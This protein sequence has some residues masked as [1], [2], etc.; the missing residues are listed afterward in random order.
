ML[1]PSKQDPMDIM[2]FGSSADSGKRGI[3][4]QRREA[5]WNCVLASS[6]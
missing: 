2:D 4:N 3:P 5:L 6:R 1:K